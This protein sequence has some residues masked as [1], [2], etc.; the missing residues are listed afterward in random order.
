[1]VILHKN[2]AFSSHIPSYTKNTNSDK[3]GNAPRYFKSDLYSFFNGQHHTVRQPE[4]W[5][6]LHH[7]HHLH[8]HHNQHYLPS[9]PSF[10][11][12]FWCSFNLILWL[13]VLSNGFYTR[14]IAR[15]A[16]AALVKI[17][18][19]A[20]DW[21]LLEEMSINYY[22]RPRRDIIITMVIMW[23]CVHI[24]PLIVCPASQFSD[25]SQIGNFPTKL[26]SNTFCAARKWEML[27]RNT[28]IIMNLEKF[29]SKSPHMIEYGWRVTE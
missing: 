18:C 14:K 21:I 10:S 11:W 19:W 26:T 7:N 2:L 12:F 28:M 27:K 24:C 9:H 22:Q 25:I 5:C 8:H 15:I 3:G 23:R 20:S 16:N 1:M 4:R 17:F 6:H 29:G 13:Y